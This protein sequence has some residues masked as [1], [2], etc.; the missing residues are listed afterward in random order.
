MGFG[1]GVSRWLSV[2]GWALVLCACSDPADPRDRQPLDT[3]VTA[4]LRQV[5]QTR[6]LRVGTAVDR[7][8]RND[9][10]GAQFKTIASREFSALTAENDMK[11]QRLQP[12]RGVFRF[13]RA[14]SLLAFAEANG[15]QMRGHTL[16]WHQ[17]NASWLTAGSWTQQ[18]ATSLLQ[19]HITTVV[20]HYRGR[21]IAW[22]VVNEALND[23][24]TRR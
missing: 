3:T 9:P 12:S 10:D 19:E 11:H 5:A 24:G 4:A 20:S 13:E 22:D 18:E 14:D 2:C 1:T 7:L 21:I 15:M 8:F 17:Q 23:D 6:G 16:I